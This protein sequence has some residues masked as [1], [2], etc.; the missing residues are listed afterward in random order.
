MPCTGC[1]SHTPSKTR[2]VVCDTKWCDNCLSK[3]ATKRYSGW[4]CDSCVGKSSKKVVIEKPYKGEFHDNPAMD[5][6]AKDW[7]GN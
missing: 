5:R 3:Y 6:L 2:C 4:K 7:L 1:G